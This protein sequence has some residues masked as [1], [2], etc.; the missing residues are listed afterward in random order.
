MIRNLYLKRYS[1]GKESTLGLLLYEKQFLSYTLENEYRQ[2][3]KQGHT[4]IPPGVY[5]VTTRHVLS[6]MTKK[7]RSRKSLSGLGFDW[8]LWLKKVP[9]FEYVYI[10]VGNSSK[11]TDGCILVGHTAN[12]N[13]SQSGFI[14]KSTDAYKRIYKMIRIWQKAG[15]TVKLHVSDYV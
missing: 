15:D 7:Y 9:G 6:G 5:D 11:D 10:H 14:G 8:H 4:R 12:N 1:S 3:K 2:V 13:H